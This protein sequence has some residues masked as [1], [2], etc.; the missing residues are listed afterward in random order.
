MAMIDYGAILK[1]DGK[2]VNK[3]KGLFMKTSDTGYDPPE[4]AY[5]SRYDNTIG[6]NGNYYVYAGDEEFLLCFY[7]C[8]FYVVSKEKVIFSYMADDDFNHYFIL[9]NGKEITVKHLDANFYTEDS[10]LDEDIYK[11]ASDYRKNNKTKQLKFLQRVFKSQYR[12]KKNPLRFKTNRYVATW[13]HNN[14]KYECIFGYGIE[15]NKD[16]WDE[17]KLEHYDFSEHERNI[18]DSWFGE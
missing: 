7:K 9:P 15:P 10:I 16:V 1:V 12:Y 11:M 8:Y 3:N 14:H 13:E 6:I 18:I 5:D 17:I 4:E 2:F